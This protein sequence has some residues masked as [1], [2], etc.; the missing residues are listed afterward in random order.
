MNDFRSTSLWQILLLTLVSIP[1]TEAQTGSS[2]TDSL[3][4]YELSE[5]V[6]GGEAESRASA[7][8]VRRISL[9]SI[10]RE[11]AASAADLVHLV[12]SAHIQTNS[13]GESLIYIRNVGERQVAVFFDG[14][15][16]N[17]PWD[18]RIDMSMIPVG[19]LGGMEVS[20]GI[21]SVVY[22]PN[23][24]GGAVNLQSRSLERSGS[25]SE[26]TG[27][28]GSNS[29]AQLGGGY[30]YR[31]GEWSAQATGSVQ[32]VDGFSLPSNAELSYSQDGE[33]VRTNTDRS[34]NNLFVRVGR[35]MDSGSEYGVSILHV[36]SEK[37]VAPEAHLD[38][39]EDR[40]RFWRYPLWR[41]TMLI[42]NGSTDL[43]VFGAVRATAWIGRFSQRIDQYETDRYVNVTDRQEDR[44]ETVGVRI[45]SGGALGSGSLRIALNYL[46]STHR[47][48]DTVLG[49]ESSGSTPTMLSYKQHLYSVGLEYEASFAGRMH[50]ISGVSLEGISMPET[51]DKPG[52]DA[53]GD[54]SV[55]AGLDYRLD[56]TVRVKL[57]GGRKVRFPT[58][59][60][61]FGEALRRFLVN[62]DLRPESSFLGDLALEL[63][64][65]RVSGEVVLFFRR[66][67]DTIDQEIVDLDGDRRRRRINLE[68]S[69]VWG[70]EF[71]GMSRI[72][73]NVK[74]DG[75]LTLM[76]SDAFERGETKPMNEKPS[77]TGAMTI[78]AS[79]RWGAS[80]RVSAVYTGRAYALTT[81]NTQV[82]L[83]TSLILNLRLAL[84]KYI[85]ENGLFAEL[86][87]GV[88]NLSDRL[89]LPQL[90]LPGAGRE[91][92][93]GLSLSF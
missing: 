76:K 44:D 88:N 38:P 5:I 21:P 22:G 59:R 6:V 69:R 62:E 72:L 52:R 37:G 1:E 36:D 85:R 93:V 40:V 2:S 42:A 61:L 57:S 46:T 19:M 29:A 75:H 65:S 25:L 90:G 80:A 31:S 39:A 41:N 53:I 7:V 35:N 83:P 63:T 12:P 91:Y 15:L 23:V 18:N 54:Y 74:A 55:M 89:T 32:S 10:V 45:S 70:V 14:A 3:R 34:I 58:M 13:R 24:I 78:S 26:F 48:T 17:I 79:T 77:V 4:T 68:G 82:K 92:R 30:L 66:T 73:E 49:T 87:A 84:R 11:D 33:L 81:R 60:E 50:V 64:G 86:Y 28:F 9:A 8:A 20:R 47:Q 27:Q 16:L 67:H 56:E 71:V 43:G 51:G